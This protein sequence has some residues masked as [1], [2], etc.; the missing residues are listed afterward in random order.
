MWV[1]G[2]IHVSFSA[3]TDF[4]PP[5]FLLLLLLKVDIM[6]YS[7]ILGIKETKLLDRCLA[8][9]RNLLQSHLLPKGLSS[10][11]PSPSSERYF[12]GI[13]DILQEYNAKKI[14]ETGYKTLTQGAQSTL[15]SVEPMVYRFRFEAFMNSSVF[16]TTGLAG[17]GAEL[18]IIGNAKTI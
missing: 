6:D 2:G 16:G 9:A 12:V 3:F 17:S 4:S 14:L 15:S 7:L 8:P 1:W 13:I 5:S 18:R 10:I 11:P